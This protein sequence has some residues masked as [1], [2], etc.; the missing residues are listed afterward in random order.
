MCQIGDVTTILDFNYGAEFERA[1]AL[2][3]GI[4]G[5][6]HLFFGAKYL[7]VNLITLSI[8]ICAVGSYHIVFDFYNDSFTA[9]V[10]G[11]SCGL[12][13]GGLTALILHKWRARAGVWMFGATAGLVVW[14]MIRAIFFH[15][16]TSYAPLYGSMLACVVIFALGTSQDHYTSPVFSTPLVGTLL[17]MEG[18]RRFTC[19][20]FSLYRFA[21]AD[22]PCYD[23]ECIFLVIA[24][25]CLSLLGFLLQYQRSKKEQSSKKFTVVDQKTYVGVSD[26]SDDDVFDSWSTDPLLTV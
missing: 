1:F 23:M 15:W 8:I 13:G 14:L 20:A 2:F 22:S 18:A 3:M 19:D 16:V 10:T 5:I 4:A 21:Q 24:A 7:M 9:F 25:I 11:T 26:A 17:M 12:I 6:V